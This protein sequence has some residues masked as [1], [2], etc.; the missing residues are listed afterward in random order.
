MAIDKRMV[1]FD[2][3]TL[4]RDKASGL[5]L[6][7][8]I[9]KFWKDQS[10]TTPKPIYQLTGA[11]GTYAYEPLP[12]TLVLGGAGTVV[13]EDGN[14]IVPYYF[15]FEG[16]PDEESQT[17]ELY[18][19]EVFNSGEEFQFSRQAWPNTSS[20]S[21]AQGNVVNYIPNGQFLIHTD[22]P[23]TDDYEAGEIRQAVTVLAQGGFY[24]VRPETSTAKDFVT[25]ERINDYVT[26]PTQSPRYAMRVKNEE[27]GTNNSYKDFRIR[28]NDVNKFASDSQQYTFSIAG[29]SAS[30][31]NVPV[32]IYVIKNYGSG[33]DPQ[34]EIPKGTITI[35]NAYDQ[36]GVSFVFGANT[37]K[38]I[39]D[40][41]DDYVE[42]AVRYPT[43]FTFD[44]KI[45]DQVLTD[46]AVTITQFPVTPNNEFT[47]QTLAGWQSVPAYNGN[48]LYLPIILTP[49]GLGYDSS[50]VGNLIFTAITD[51]NLSPGEAWCDGSQHQYDAYWDDG[52]PKSRLGDKIWN[53]SLN[54]YQYGTGTN[55]FSASIRSLLPTPT[56]TEV[57]LLRNNNSGAVTA[58]TAGTSGFT[59]SQS[60]AGAAVRAMTASFFGSLIML[61]NNA[62][63]TVSLPTAGTAGFNPTL[64]RQS[65]TVVPQFVY[66]TPLAASGLA[67]LYWLYNAVGTNYYIWYRVNG[68]GADPAIGGR[69]GIRV[70]LISTDDANTVA[71]K[72]IYA[73]NGWEGT[74]ITCTAA[75]SITA[76]TYWTAN[77]TTTE[78]YI[79]YKKDGAGTDPALS[80][81]TGILVEIL[82]A[83]TATEVATK[84]L[85]AI[86]SKYYALPNPQGM[87]LRVLDPEGIYDTSIRF[88]YVDGIYGQVTGGIETDN[89]LYHGHT[90]TNLAGTGT[91]STAATVVNNTGNTLTQTGGAGGYQVSTVGVTVTTNSNGT[92]DP[93]TGGSEVAVD[94]MAFRLKIKY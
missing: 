74:V 3:Q 49:T 86:N 90:I 61:E 21:V 82:S 84:T 9:I 13:D 20:T 85:I 87:V 55:Y 27:V 62:G 33:G 41:N 70:D 63:G 25:F 30:A 17:V 37:G 29:Q 67:G 16:T 12:T 59:V 36:Q 52:V 34:E 7:A 43:S 31:G 76:G 15:P 78:F 80:G 28:F 19:I 91:G 35:G 65:T 26:N 71:R 39:G 51:T 58:S 38:T 77:S 8:G 57:I 46:G 93:Y 23:A 2:L 79:W 11:P 1:I 50:Q 72:T 94:N 92:T 75:S 5:P 64:V 45:T 32:S 60:S 47:Y 22:I 89:I 88:S 73:I 4:F 83:D 53:S 66:V 56:P 40:N 68:A 10:R 42:I 18:F 44:I 6:S 69:T 14:D 81:K 48:N 54:V 24:F